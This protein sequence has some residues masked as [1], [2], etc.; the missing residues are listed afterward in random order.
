MNACLKFISLQTRSS[1]MFSNDLRMTNDGVFFN[2]IFVNLYKA[3]IPRP[4][5]IELDIDTSRRNSNY[6]QRLFLKG[7]DKKVPSVDMSL[8]NATFYTS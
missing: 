5:Q 6:Q 3:N 8:S 7:I 4:I 1:F 2:K